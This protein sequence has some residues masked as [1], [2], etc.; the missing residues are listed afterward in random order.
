[1]AQGALGFDLKAYVEEGCSVDS[2]TLILAR[3]D[4]VQCEVESMTISL[5]LRASR[6]VVQ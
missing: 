4:E 5:L 1:M 3:S 2:C 6:A